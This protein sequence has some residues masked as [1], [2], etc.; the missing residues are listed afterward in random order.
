MAAAQQR[1]GLSITAR[2]A[3]ILHDTLVDKSVETDHYRLS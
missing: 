1:L 2:Q 3:D